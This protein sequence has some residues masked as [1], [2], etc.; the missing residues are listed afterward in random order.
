MDPAKKFYVFTQMFHWVPNDKEFWDS[1]KSYISRYFLCRL[2]YNKFRWT[3]GVLGE[4]Q[5]SGNLENIPHSVLTFSLLEGFGLQG[6]TWESP[7]AYS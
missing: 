6:R 2:L 1:I 3:L 5:F 7:G 4:K